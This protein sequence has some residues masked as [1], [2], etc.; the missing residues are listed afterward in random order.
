MSTTCR[1]EVWYRTDP[2]SRC[3]RDKSPS[4]KQRERRRC[5]SRRDKIAAVS[6]APWHRLP[7][8]LTAAMRPGLAV[9]VQAVV[10][11]VAEATPAFAVIEDSK[12]GRDVRTAVRVALERFLDLVGTDEVALPPRFRDVFVSL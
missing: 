4:P 7:A 8:E 6:T 9:S 3:R 12:V 11:A 10:D 2:Y 1:R 5:L